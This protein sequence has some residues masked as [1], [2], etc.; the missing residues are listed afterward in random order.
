[1]TF[2]RNQNKRATS[3]TAFYGVV[4]VRETTPHT[5]LSTRIL[6]YRKLYTPFILSTSYAQYLDLELCILL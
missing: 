4:S 5:L 3:V 1:M 2:T 6:R